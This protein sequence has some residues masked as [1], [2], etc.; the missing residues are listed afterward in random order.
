MK[1]N[2]GIR[3]EEVPSCFLCGGEGA[4]FY[5]NLRDRFFNAPGVWTLL[6]CPN[7]HL[8]WLNPRPVSADIDKLYGGYYT[9]NHGHNASYFGGWRTALQNSILEVHMGY[10]NLKSSLLLR[11]LGKMFSLVRPIKERVELSVMSLEGNKLGKLLDV[12]CGSA[13][14]LSKMRNLGWDVF[15]V[16]QDEKAVELARSRFGLHVEKGTVETVRFA[17]DTF[18]A[19]TMNHVFEHF[20]DPIGSLRECRRILKKDGR[21]IILTPNIGSLGSRIFRHAWMHLDPPRH[22]YI[23]SRPTLR[24]CAERA[25]LSI[26]GLKTTARTAHG[27][28]SMSYSIRQEGVVPNCLVQEN[29]CLL[30]LGGLCFWGIESGFSWTDGLGEE[31][32]LVATKDKD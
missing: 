20:A 28:W 21:L 16:E 11:V 26:Q 24:A 6:R 25:N 9:H 2:E 1:D 13:G 23:F 8:V 31:L 18:D 17:E 3:V 27:V 14:F 19:I 29:G 4:L 15:G 5:E 32:A 10:K 7:C 30:T 22:F 12:G